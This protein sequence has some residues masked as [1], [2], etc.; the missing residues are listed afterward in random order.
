MFQVTDRNQSQSTFHPQ[1]IDSQPA[2]PWKLWKIEKDFEIGRPLGEGK[3][4]HVYLA[5]TKKERFIV[6]LKVIHAKQIVE[7]KM[8]HQINR[9]TDIHIKLE[10][11]NIIQMYGYFRDMD[12]IVYVLEFAPGGEVYT[13]LLNEEYKRFSESK[14]S[15]YIYQ[16]T[17]ALNYLHRN[18]IIHR[19]I[20]PE[21][22]LLGY[23]GEIKMADFGW[24]IENTSTPTVRKARRKTLCGTLDYLPPEMVKG[25]TYDERVDLWC[26]GVLCY[27]FL[28]GNPP[29]ET[30]DRAATY[31]KIAELS[32]T[33]PKWVSLEAQRFINKIL[34]HDPSKRLSLQKVQNHP[35]ITT[36]RMIWY[37]RTNATS[38][39][40][41]QEVPS[42]MLSALN[43][44][45][46][47]L[48]L[49]INLHQ[50]YR[51]EK[52]KKI[53]IHS[54]DNLIDSISSSPPT[55]VFEAM[56]V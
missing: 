34:V 49:V 27:E 44:T 22:L 16:I 14:A 8:Q 10:H 4:G 46:I 36:N 45:K 51:E 56:R 40:P 15:T 2:K 31:K 6:A 17:H 12:K 5:R 19:D 41:D 21:N 47:D 33:Y 23:Y 52:L 29:F 32:F 25:Q 37:C 55:S 3:F 35:W 42:A 28:V 54:M 1:K 20:K 26:L 53:R 43:V 39:Q 50:L 48:T 18:N 24:S 30:H 13:E 7:D 38:W 11:P 9:E